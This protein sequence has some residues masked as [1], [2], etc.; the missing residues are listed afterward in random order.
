MSLN[1]LITDGK[2]QMQVCN[3]CR[4]CEGY[5]AVWRAIEW[6]RTFTENDMAYLANLCHDCKECVF[7]CPFTT[8]HEFGIHP[9]KLFSGLREELYKKYS[10]PSGLA[11]AIGNKGGFWIIAIVAFL[12]IVAIVAGTNGLPTLLEQHAGKGS[13]YRVLS[14]AFLEVT[15]GALGIWFIGGWMIGAVRFW[16][17]IRSTTPERVQGVD[18][19]KAITYALRLRYL[20]DEETEEPFSGH[21]K[22]L[23]HS[24]FYGFLLDVASTTLAA[25]YAHIF[26]IQAPYPFYHPVVILGTLGGIGI[27]IGTSGLIYI[28]S[29]SN[30]ANSNK[31]AKRS[32]NAFSISLLTI[33]VTGMLVLICRDTAP[34]GIILALH[35]SSVASLFFTAPYTKFVHFIYRFLALVQYAQEE[36]LAES[37]LTPKVRKEN[38]NPYR[39]KFANRG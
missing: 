16:R 5:C 2:R 35:L 36:R 27:I 3:A 6:R 7:A 19:R 12:L 17:D 33:A 26:H 30:D 13:F 24:V 18:I 20:G 21:R 38:S 1:E 23:H 4:Y 37:H 11:K 14:E 39:G 28:K 9:P 32:G 29:R 22:W 10:W 25:V 8:P 15:F 34:M 31:N